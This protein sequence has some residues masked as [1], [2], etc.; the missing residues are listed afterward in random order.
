MRRFAN[1]AKYYNGHWA[2]RLEYMLVALL[3]IGAFLALLIFRELDDNM[4]VSWR[5]VFAAAD[6]HK[7]LLIILLG[8]AAAYM[9][10][11]IS[12]PE[13]LF[14]PLLFFLS[15]L[16]AV[17][18]W[19][20]PEVIVDTSRYFTQAKHLAVYGAGYYF[21]EWGRN[22]SAWTDMP[23]VPFLYGL[24]F[25]ALGESRIYIQIFTTILF[26][27]TVALTY[28]IGKILW[29]DN[30]GFFGGLLLLGIP[31]LYT[32][33]PLMLVDVPV[34][35]FFTLA[36]YAFIKAIDR[37]G[38]GLIVLSSIAIF[39]TIFSKYS[40]PVMLSGLAVILAVYA[41]GKRED[42]G[43]FGEPGLSKASAQRLIIFRGATVFAI[44]TLLIGIMVYLKFDIMSG[45]VELLRSYQGP[46]LK[47][48]GESSISTFLFQIH[49]FVTVAAIYSAYVAL[50]RKDLKYAVIGW[51][52]LLVFLLQIERIRYIIMVF[53]ML[54]LAAAYG[55]NEIKS[56]RLKKFTVLCA[57]SMS[58][59]VAVFGYLPFLQGISAVNLKDAGK[60]LDANGTKDIEV[61][62]LPQKDFK[63][64]NPAVAVPVLDLFTNRN[65]AYR[66][67]YKSPPTEL[68]NTSSLR[69]TWEYINPL[70]YIPGVSD[71]K[72][73]NGNITVVI[74][75]GSTGETI[76]SHIMQRL[77]DYKLSKTFN[78]NNELFH[79]Q[80]IVSVYQPDKSP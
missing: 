36:V 26:S 66:Y 59:I 65:I 8:I 61:F 57:V 80:T 27:A 38:A 1:T 3:T 6:S 45:Q 41:L 18:F 63:E 76:P 22:I 29:N 15:F 28:Q 35:F 62:V 53:P 74:I 47:R 68:I 73:A 5:W 40:T 71:R 51:I 20:A 46:G 23:L 19:A 43:Y 33:V 14:A 13:K 67:D 39:L 58:F 64:A 4:L 10:S 30:I 70:Y 55:L 31:Y 72:K 44:A 17:P 42:K 75:S 60:Y 50:K 56:E 7:V 49:P 48:W 37:G 52:I 11:R 77:E 78:T 34:M 79:Y 24:I 25:K 32:Q 54:A 9:L 12:I 21:N 2:A 16:A 69:F